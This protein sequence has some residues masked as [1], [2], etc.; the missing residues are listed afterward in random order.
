MKIWTREEIEALLARSDAA[1]L[2][3]IIVIYQKQTADEQK[4]HITRNVNGVGFSSPDASRG[5]FH[6]QYLIKFPDYSHPFVKE[7][8]LPCWKEIRKNN[9]MRIMKYAKQLA[10]IANNNVSDK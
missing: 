1:V 6:A 10:N 4:S 2:R 7:K 3:A 5:T 8:I 9:K